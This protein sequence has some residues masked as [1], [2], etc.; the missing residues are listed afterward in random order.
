MMSDK[1]LKIFSMTPGSAIAHYRITAKIGEGG[2]GAVYLATDIKLNRD[3]A[4][5]VLP[6]TLANDP[7][8]LARFTREAQVLASLNHPNIAIIY[9][10]EE[11][12][13]V[14][15]LVPGCTLEERIAAGPIP[16][17]ET[18]GI[19]R[20]IAEALEAAHEKG[21]IHRDL[22]PANVKITPEGVVKVLDFGLAKAADSISGATS[23]NSPTITMLS[24]HGGLIMGT[25]GYMA[26][27]QAAARPVDRRADIWSFGVVLWEMLTGHQLFSGETISH[28]LA[29]VLRA[30]IDFSKLPASTPAPIAELVKRCLDRDS[31]KRLRDIGEARIVLQEYLA[32]PRSRAEDSR[33]IKPLPTK[34]AWAPWVVAA[35]LAA[36]LGYVTYQHEQEPPPKMMKLSVLPP[37]KGTFVGSSPPALSPDGRKLA[38]AALQEGKVLLWIRDLDSPTAHSVTGTDGASDPFWSPNSQ[39]IGFF[40]H[41]DKLK[42]VD[43]GGGTVQ[44]LCTTQGASHG[45]SWSSRGVILFANSPASA[46]YRVSATGGSP[47]PVTSL[48]E[49]AGEVSHRLP[50]FLP[51][52]RHFLFSVRNQDQVNK[53]AVYLGDLD[54][55]ERTLVLKG[56]AHA[57]YV[58]AGGF[59]VF[60][61]AN[62]ADSPLMARAMD[63]WRFRTTDNPISIVDSVAFSTGIWAQ[64]Q[65]SV[66]RDGVLV[67]T[68]GGQSKT[69]H[70]TWLDRAGKTLGIVEAPAALPGE[71]AISPDGKAIAFY[72]LQSGNRDIW[73]HDVT[74]GVTSRFTFSPSGGSAYSPAWSPDG[75]YLIFS[76][77]DAAGRTSLMKK[78]IAGG[79]AP[80]PI[81]SPWGDPVR[82]PLYGNWSR[83][84]RYVIAELFPNG[85]TG[86]DIWMLRLNPTG[87]KPRPYLQSSARESMPSISPS[88]DWLAYTSDETHRFE[89]YVQSFPNPG[90]KYQV[91]VN[92]G[93]K[94]VWSRDGK[95]LF[96]IAPDQQMMAVA[97]R[98]NGANLEIGTATALF[99]SK[100][101][102]ANRF[103]VA[104]DGRFLIPVQEQSS[105]SPMT[106]VVN[107]QMGLK[108]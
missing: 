100:L 66:S 85:P 17:E 57:A 89:V 91:S 39:S 22:K 95:E 94:P 98:N 36:T 53:S 8:Y 28:T 23:A 59:L 90:Q 43:S 61:A 5:K 24:R 64:H 103:D 26:P 21:V 55:K 51:D 46:L 11:K 79:G 52:G 41:G 69:P 6:D 15:E 38:F 93:E 77:R 72:S 97:I 30:P 58:P 14:M 9:G 68:S 99:D 96:Y 75:R 88:S 104:K 67:Y 80:E 47:V 65:F 49:A 54:S 44:T 18:I 50:W 13:L 40:D 70:L 4:I 29:D 86:S 31:K 84:G 2:M 63:G 42:R 101:A 107:W 34:L 81:G 3:V 74:R 56:E 62:T 82:T 12:A 48:D 20:Q 108:K 105:S 33:E 10:V 32:D 71:P 37:D 27:E 92:G 25:A 35:G 45:A 7:D 87:E 16:V 1:I 73:V 60:A 78:P 102:P 19:A 76:Y 106:V 83:D